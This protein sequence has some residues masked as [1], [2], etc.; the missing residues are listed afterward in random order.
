MRRFYRGERLWRKGIRIGSVVLGLLGLACLTPIRSVY[1]VEMVPK[2]SGEGHRIDPVD[3]TAVY[4]REGLQVRVRFLKD[5]ELVGEIPGEQNPYVYPGL[6]DPKLGYR[7][8]QFTVFQV[9]VVNPTFPKVQLNPEQVILKTDRGKTLYPYAITLAEAKGR[10]RNFETY[11]L[12]KG[13]QTGNE[14]ALYLERMGLVRETIYHRDAPVFKGNS[15][16]GKIIFDSL[17]PETTGVNLVISDFVLRFGV[18]D[19]PEEFLLIG[20]P[21]SVQQ[22]IRNP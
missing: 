3:S 14:Q 6:F 21:F 17:S 13:V 8:V 19:E 20:F 9:S 1:R 12:S 11:F 18:H 7:P 2:I 4:T 16:F 5:E 15:Y 10:L 22:G